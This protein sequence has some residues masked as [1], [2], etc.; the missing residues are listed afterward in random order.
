M[1]EMIQNT[2][3]VVILYISTALVMTSKSFY[4]TSI[5]Y[6]PYVRTKVYYD[7]GREINTFP[8]ANHVCK[9]SLILYKLWTKS[10]SHTDQWV[11]PSFAHHSRN[12]C[13]LVFKDK[14]LCGVRK[15]KI[16]SLNLPVVSGKHLLSPCCWFLLVVV[17]TAGSPQPVLSPVLPSDKHLLYVFP[18]IS[19][20]Y[21]APS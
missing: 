1:W 14:F 16:F 6:V 15:R 12:P 19:A 9:Q 11:L 4:L 3:A 18:A 20:F 7:R 8:F 10:L 2:C 5:P 17:A 13:S 21:T